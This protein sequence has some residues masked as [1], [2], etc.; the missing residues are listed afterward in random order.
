[1]FVQGTLRETSGAGLCEQGA[2]QEEMKSLQ[3]FYTKWMLAEI[4]VDCVDSRT[5]VVTLHSE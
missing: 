1:M 2:E 5:D 3:Y 4:L